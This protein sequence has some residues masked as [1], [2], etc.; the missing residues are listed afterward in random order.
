[1]KKPTLIIE[2]DTYPSGAKFR[3]VLAGDTRLGSYDIREDGFLPFGC[4]KVI[5]NEKAAQ[6]KVI[7]RYIAA[8]LGAAAKAAA[9]LEEFELG[10]VVE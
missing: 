1:M 8:R 4:R 9:L 10:D 3:R 5:A 7:Q 2:D 6:V